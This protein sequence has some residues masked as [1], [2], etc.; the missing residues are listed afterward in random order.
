MTVRVTVNQLFE[1]GRE[2]Q[3]HIELKL[4]NTM[5]VPSLKAAIMQHI[6]ASVTWSTLK[7]NNALGVEGM[8]VPRRLRVIVGEANSE[9]Q[10]L[11]EPLVIN[12][13][14]SFLQFFNSM[15]EHH[16]VDVL[17]LL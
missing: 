9:N 13:R 16:G 8:Q 1:P 3:E 4:P 6:N 17:A 11:T 7:L 12:P 2:Q 10:Y 5:T 14:T 15:L